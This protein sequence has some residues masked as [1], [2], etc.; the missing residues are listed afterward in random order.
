MTTAMADSANW[1]GSGTCPNGPAIACVYVLLS[2]SETQSLSMPVA[3]PT[4]AC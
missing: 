2:L 1:L 3:D 4:G